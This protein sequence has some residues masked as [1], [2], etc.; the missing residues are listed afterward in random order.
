M[1]LYGMVH[2]QVIFPQTNGSGT[3][4]DTTRYLYDIIKPGLK[5]TKAY[6]TPF[7]PASAYR[8]WAVKGK[9]MPY[10]L[11][12]GGG[13][14]ALLGVEYGLGKHHS[15]G[16]DAYLLSGGSPGEEYDTL[17]KETI[18]TPA[19][20][21]TDRALFLN[22]RYYFGLQGLRQNH[23][24]TFYTG[25][26]ARYGYLFYTFENGYKT[27][28]L[29]QNETHYSGG[30]LLGSI[31]RVKDQMGIDVNVGIYYKEIYAHKAYTD[32]GMTIREDKSHSQVSARIGLNFELW[33]LRNKP[34]KPVPQA[35]ETLSDAYVRRGDEKFGL[36]YYY[37]AMRDYKLAAVADTN[38][39]VAYKKKAG[40]KYM[41]EKYN[42][43]FR[44]YDKAIRKNPSDVQALY[45]R[46]LAKLDT[47]KDE[48]ALADAIRVHQLDSL[49]RGAFYLKGVVALHHGR[50]NDALNYLTRV[51][52][53]DSI[54]YNP[55]YFRGLANYR[56]GSY[57]E[58][59]RDFS[60]ALVLK[61]GTDSVYNRR[62]FAK[63]YSGDYRGALADFSKTGSDPDHEYMH[64]G[65]GLTFFALENYDE[66]LK[67]LN[68]SVHLSRDF[69]YTYYLRGEVKSK[70]LKYKAAVHDYGQALRHSSGTYDYIYRGRAWAYY[71]LG[72]SKRALADINQALAI[73]AADAGSY[74]CRAAIYK[75]MN[76][77]EK[78]AADLDKAKSLTGQDQQK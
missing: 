10:V 19:S 74:R 23:G 35:H 71:N 76:D 48:E 8:N 12:N 51:T 54:A 47:H 13:I 16:I 18:V 37:G 58:A 69:Y 75:Q 27:H 59:I 39:A 30:I 42:Q 9:A 17:K 45:L 21:S 78:A 40:V 56:L 77:A 50:N 43:A 2:A 29:S 34:H 26:F 46:G 5:K 70:L 32:N 3:D 1:F 49:H 61:P 68:K 41:L 36:H 65:R 73:D 52:E 72:E 33:F 64:Y 31:I 55:V 67:E 4:A 22:Y 60:R 14:N 57:N 24:L 44:Y 11:G 7:D 15:L 53:K 66:A 6:T 63:Y 38:N 20:G 25:A 62:A 28:I